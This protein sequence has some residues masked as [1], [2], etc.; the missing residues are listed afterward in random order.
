MGDPLPPVTNIAESRDSGGSLD[1][2]V[3]SP[4][5]EATGNR[6]AISSQGDLASRAEAES[7]GQGKAG[8]GRA[9][10]GRAGQDRAGEGRA[11]IPSL[12]SS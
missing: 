12:W 5:T 6:P 9:V 11:G 8:Q 3:Q 7:T 4:E 2:F 10:R 1:P